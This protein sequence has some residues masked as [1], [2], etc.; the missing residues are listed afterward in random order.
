MESITVRVHCVF[1]TLFKLADRE[2][3]ARYK[4]WDCLCWSAILINEFI[5][6]GTS[7]LLSECKVTVLID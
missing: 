3:G 4:S 2:S 7:E 6:A 5:T 1:K